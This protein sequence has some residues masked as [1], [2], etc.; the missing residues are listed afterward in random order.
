MNNE[1]IDKALPPIQ[2]QQ[3]D[4]VTS[5]AKAVLGMVP[6][7]GSLLVELAGNVIPN[8]RIDRLSKFS[9]E[10]EAR[11]AKLD[12]DFVRSKLSDENFT[13]LMEEGMRQAAKSVS[14]ER[15]QYL[16][17]L[18]ANGVDDVA[19]SFIESKHLLRILGELNDIEILWLR[20]YL[21]PGIG[22]D[23]S[24]IEKH[25]EV[26]EPVHAHIGCDQATLDKEALRQ[27][28]MIHMTELGV[29][30]PRYDTDMKTKQPVFDMFSGRMRI[31]GY[32]ITLLGKLLLRQISFASEPA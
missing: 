5:A 11:L 12:K 26:F 32:E 6:F 1:N 2:N 17:S 13:D 4:Y 9:A 22:G 15:R 30:L 27:S 25:K 18:L 29:L 31:R 28:Y 10:L 21:N 19:V 20:F 16:A 23:S 14:D 7:A 24:F 3:V 8:Q